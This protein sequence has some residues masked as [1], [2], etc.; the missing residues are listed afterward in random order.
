[1]QKK[2]TTFKHRIEYLLF[3]AFIFLVKVSPLFL[4]KFN[5]RML[6]RLGR[7]LSKKHFHI[8][9]KNLKIA[10]PDNSPEQTA[11]LRDA[12][13]HHFSSI[14]VEIIYMFVKKNPEKILKRIDVHNIEVLGKALEKKK[15]VILFSAHF[16]NWELAPLLLSRY[17]N[18]PIGSIAREMDNPLVESVVKKFREHMGSTIIYK[19]NAAR[20]MLKMLDANRVIFLLIDQNTIDREAVFVDF[21]GQRVGAVPSVSQLYL[22]K[23]I[24]VIPL[25]LHYEEDRIVLEL[26]DELQFDRTGDHKNDVRG[27]TQL[28]MNIIEENIRKNPEQWFWFHDRWKNRE[29]NKK[30]GPQNTRKTQKKE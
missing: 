27:V 1:M 17:L 5:K 20:T 9:E 21:F 18:M 29:K 6:N 25:F 12:V 7:R 26:L 14:F 16:G 13:Y 8:V 4:A 23:D 10:F 28:C 3:A 19:H 22:K 15:G 2:K 24:P 11:M 30:E